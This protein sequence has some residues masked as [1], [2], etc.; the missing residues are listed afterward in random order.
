MNMKQNPLF[1]QLEL[2]CIELNSE[3]QESHVENVKLKMTNEELSRALESTSQELSL[4][5]EQLTMLQEQAARL[6]Q[7][8]EM[9]VETLYS[10]RLIRSFFYIFLEK[11]VV[12]FVLFKGDVQSN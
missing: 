5:Q 1:W 4:A 7:E 3:R 12:V 6:R 8:K 2:Q 11:S 10:Q 9:L